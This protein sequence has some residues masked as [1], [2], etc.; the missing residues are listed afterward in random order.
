FYDVTE[1]AF[2]VDKVAGGYGRDSIPGIDYPLFDPPGSDRTS[3]LHAGHA[4]LGLVFQDGPRAYPLDLLRKIEVVND[5]G[6]GKP[7]AIVYDRQPHRAQVYD[8]QIDNRPVT[9][10]TTGYAVGSTEDPKDGTP[11]LYDRKTSSLWLPEETAL[12]CVN[13]KLKGTKLP[14]A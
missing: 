1:A 10:G 7:F 3:K 5:Q 13:G 4:V 11:L 9:F 6:D 14:V 8:R 2:E 12:V